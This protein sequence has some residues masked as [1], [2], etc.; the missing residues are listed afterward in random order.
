[1]KNKAE[2]FENSKINLI[3]III[4][5]SYFHCVPLKINLHSI[6]FQIIIE[7][8]T[9]VSLIHRLSDNYSGDVPELQIDWI[10]TVNVSTGVSQS[11]WELLLQMWK[12]FT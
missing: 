8:Q 11:I 2:T 1:M 9:T 6:I 5:C 10:I 3:V 7:V 12:A 4:L